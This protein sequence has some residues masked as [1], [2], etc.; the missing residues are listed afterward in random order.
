[1]QVNVPSFAV[2]SSAEVSLFLGSAAHLGK[3][4]NS[5]AQLKIMLTTRNQKT[6]VP[7]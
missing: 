1:M 7:T 5:L 2:V 6:A 4:T 3:T